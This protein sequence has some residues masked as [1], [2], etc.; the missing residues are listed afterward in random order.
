MCPCGSYKTDNHMLTLVVGENT[1]PKAC[2]D[3]RQQI[4]DNK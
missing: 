4:T 2:V 1:Q 3:N